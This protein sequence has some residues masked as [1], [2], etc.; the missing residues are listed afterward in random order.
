MAIGEFLLEWARERRLV[1]ET[2]HIV[3]E[4]WVGRAYEL[5]AA[6]EQ[7]AIPHSFCLADSQEGR[8]LLAKAGPGVKLPLMILG[9]GTALNDPTDSEIAAAVGAPSDVERRRS[10]CWSS[11][12]GR[13]AFRLRCTGR[14][15]ACASLSSTLAVSAARRGRA[16]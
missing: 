2:V 13:P 15:R 4:Q 5:R 6:A 7:C 9:D 12:P 1:P 3:G 10:I 8:A 11:V 16:R 14:P